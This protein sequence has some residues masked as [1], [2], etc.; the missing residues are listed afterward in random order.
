MKAPA[1]EEQRRAALAILSKSERLT[2]KAGSLLGQ[3]VA[4]DTP[5]SEAQLSW[6]LI[7]AERAGVEVSANVE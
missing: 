5:M 4:D 2:R 7:L 3:L 6:F 1:Y